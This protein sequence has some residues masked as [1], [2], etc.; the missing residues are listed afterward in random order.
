[1]AANY[2]LNTN[3]EEGENFESVRKPYR[4]YDL[5]KPKE[6]KVKY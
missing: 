3:F 4:P 2:V 6:K 5:L 1:M